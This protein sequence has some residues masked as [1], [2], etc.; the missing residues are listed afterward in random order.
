MKK[1]IQHPFK[2]FDHDSLQFHFF[3]NNFFGAC[4]LFNTN[5]LC[6]SSLWIYVDGKIKEI[7]SSTSPIQ[8]NNNNSLDINIGEFSIKEEE[9]G[10]FKIALEDKN[11]SIFLQSKN[12]ETWNDTISSVIHLPNMKAKVYYHDKVYDGVG[13]SKRYSWKPAPG[14]WGYRFIQGFD[15]NDQASIWTAE[16]T[17]GLKKYDY[18][19]ILKSDGILINTIDDMSMHRQNHMIA[20]TTH[21]TFRIELEEIDLWGVNLV[22]SKMD[23]LLQQRLCKFE[24]KLENKKMHGYAINETCYG[25]LG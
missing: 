14:H 20:K 1:I 25:T 9:G 10:N 7:F 19:K 8:S 23:S 17:F 16:A 24:A 21:G 3:C 4:R 13:Y 2:G 11:I 15:V 6:H 12:L 5:S 22:S 18:F